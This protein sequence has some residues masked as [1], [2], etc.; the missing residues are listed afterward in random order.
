MS[1][2]IHLHIMLLILSHLHMLTVCLTPPRL[3]YR[4]KSFWQRSNRIGKSARRMM[5][6]YYILPTQ[7]RDKLPAVRI[8]LHVFVWALRRLDGQVHCYDKAVDLGILPGSRVLDPEIVASANCDLIKGLVL[9][10]GCLPISH[11]KPSMHHFVHYG[12]YTA[13]HGL[14]RFYWM[15]FFE[16]YNYLMKTLVRD[17]NKKLLIHCACWLTFCRRDRYETKKTLCQVW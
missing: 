4:G 2:L 17:Q 1:L 11:L 9:L 6:L 14:L 3:C 13:T 12:E 8:A 7:L 5:L 10:E 15:F 16:R